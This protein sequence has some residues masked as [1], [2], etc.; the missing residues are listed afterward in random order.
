MNAAAE[1]NVPVGPARQIERLGMQIGRGI[2]IGGGQHR[3][4]PLASLHDDAAEI[5][6][7]AS[8][9]SN[10]VAHIKEKLGVDSIGA[11]VAYAHRVGLVD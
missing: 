1:G 5:D 10:H 3:H 2:H 7:A 4:D 11:I 6:V 9:V 8:T